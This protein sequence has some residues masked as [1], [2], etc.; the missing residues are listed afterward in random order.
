MWTRVICREVKDQ[1]L[2]KGDFIDT[3]EIDQIVKVKNLI[4]IPDYL[5]SFESFILKFRLAGCQKIQLQDFKGKQDSLFFQIY[6][7]L[8]IDV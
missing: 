4:M 3:G 8:P 6:F 1:P 7:Q 2:I 5:K